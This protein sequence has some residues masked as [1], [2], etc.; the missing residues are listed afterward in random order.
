VAIGFK[1]LRELGQA[2][3]DVAGDLGGFLA[4]IERVRIGEDKAQALANLRAVEIAEEN[5]VVSGI[6]KPL[7]SSAGA[8]ELGVEIEGVANIADDEKRRAAVACREMRDVVAALV[9]GALEGFVESGTS[10]AAVA[11]FC[12]TGRVGF[13]NALLGFQNKV[14]GFVEI[15]VVRHGG[16]VGGH[17]SDGA[18]EDEEIFLGIGR[19]GVRARHLEEVAEFGKEHLVIRPLGSARVSPAGYKGFD[20]IQG[21]WNARR[22]FAKCGEMKIRNVSGSRPPLRVSPTYSHIKQ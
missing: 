1:G 5:A 8:G 7:V 16:S 14:R 2:G 9:I 20:R 19:S 12:R 6:G 4:G 15:D 10:P 11:G 17:A 18:I 21:W 13:T 3:G 22:G